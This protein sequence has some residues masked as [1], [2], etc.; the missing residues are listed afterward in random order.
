MDHLR[1]PPQAMPASG[2]QLATGVD[3]IS[4]PRIERAF[5]RYGD[6]FLARI[7]TQN[8]IDHCRGRGAQLATRF[9]A[10]EAAAKAL[11]VGMRLMSP[12]GIGWPEV[13]TLNGPSGQ[14]YLVLHDQAAELA[15]A[16]GLSVWAVSLSHDA[17]FAVAFVVAMRG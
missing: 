4:I 17:G 8:E 7:Y 6:R 12:Y 10:K 2:V 16:Q 3:I 5:A 14:P 11:G 15:E 1:V 9:A 13:E